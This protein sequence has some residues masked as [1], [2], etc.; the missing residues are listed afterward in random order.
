MDES[1]LDSPDF[2]ARLGRVAQLWHHVFV[3]RALSLFAF[4]VFPGAEGFLD[5]AGQWLAMA[6]GLGC[7]LVLTIIGQMSRKRRSVSPRR[8]RAATALAM[9]LIALGT[10]LTSAAMFAATAV[11]DGSFYFDA[12]TA[13][14]FGAFLVA[15]SACAIARP[16][17]FTFAGAAAFG[18]AIGVASW[19]FAAAGVVF[20]G[21]LIVMVREDMRHQRRT[22][23][24]ERLAV[25]EQQR[26][27][28]LVRDFERA[29]RGWFWET[30]RYGQLV[31]ISHHR[32][33][34]R[35]AA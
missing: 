4:A 20:L 16:V 31:Y 2:V 35:P 25:S 1:L 10:L 11:P 28:N 7:D 27:L 19:P 29:G 17:F 33:E 6:A 15:A 22:K 14:L 30:D 24:A 23:G 18:G 9:A 21:L 12:F 8:L 5:H 34:A 13:I 26:A 32:G 3:A